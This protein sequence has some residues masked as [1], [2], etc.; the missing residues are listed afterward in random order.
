MAIPGLSEAEVI[1][2]YTKVYQ[3][4]RA[5]RLLNISNIQKLLKAY[6]MTNARMMAG[7]VLG[8]ATGIGGILLAPFTGKYSI[9]IPTKMFCLST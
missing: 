3:A 2:N 4:W 6:N 9:K 5:N 1:Y 7:G 8:L